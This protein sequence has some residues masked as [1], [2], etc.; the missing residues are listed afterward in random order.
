MK[1]WILRPVEDRP[2]SDDPWEPWYDKCFG[3]IVRCETEDGARRYA[4]ASAGDENSRL[5]R[6]AIE[7]LSPWLDPK[8]STCVELTQDGEPGLV[9]QD[10]HAA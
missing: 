9:M 5:T 1:L 7:K 4:H 3:F 8:Y 6:N 2:L 10:F